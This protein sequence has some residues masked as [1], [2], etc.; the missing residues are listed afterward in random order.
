MGYGAFWDFRWRMIDMQMKLVEFV[1]QQKILFI[2]TKNID[3]I[4]NVQEISI[5]EREAAAVNKV[6][7]N[8]KSYIGRLI[9]IWMECFFLPYV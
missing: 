4:R 7:S 2:T 9:E 1:K 6:Y 3:Y 5:L 8:K